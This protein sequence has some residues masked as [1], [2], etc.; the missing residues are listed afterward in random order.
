[1]TIFCFNICSLDFVAFTM[2][3]HFKCMVHLGG[4]FIRDGDCLKCKGVESC[5]DPIEDKWSYFE[6][7]WLLKQL[8]YAKEV[9]L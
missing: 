2:Y 1:M 4:K 6:I 9:V 7:L 3:A 8:D 5:W